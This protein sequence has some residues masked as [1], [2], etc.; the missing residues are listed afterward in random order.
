ML[1]NKITPKRYL[2]LFNKAK[3]KNSKEVSQRKKEKQTIKFDNIMCLLELEEICL[4]Y[5]K[6]NYDTIKT[7]N[8]L[9][10][11]EIF[12]YKDLKEQFLRQYIRNTSSGY[13]ATTLE[14]NELEDYIK[15]NITEAEYKIL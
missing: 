13:F 3:T 6:F 14:Y 7:L 11:K 15:N 4:D 9:L 1:Q 8:K 12:K 10:V 5:N 2:E